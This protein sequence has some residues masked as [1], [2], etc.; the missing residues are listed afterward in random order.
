MRARR[1][2]VG[3]ILAFCLAGA[4]GIAATG[5]QDDRSARFDRQTWLRPVEY[6]AKS[7]R[8]TMV[9]DLVDKH[10]KVGKPMTQVRKLL[11]P[12]DEATRRYWFYMVSAEDG[13]FLPTCVGLNLDINR[14]RLQRAIVTHDD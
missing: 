5:W 9:D 7:A 4:L 11:G 2:V 8:G 10:L 13:S 1:I 14:G 3:A 6:C 12:P